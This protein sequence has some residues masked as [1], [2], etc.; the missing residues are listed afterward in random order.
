MFSFRYLALL[1]SIEIVA[2]E[3]PEPDPDPE[4]EPEPEEQENGNVNGN[5][6]V[7]DET[8]ENPEQVRL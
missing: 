4:I 1:N 7:D 2:T 6:H 8:P 5:G 3:E